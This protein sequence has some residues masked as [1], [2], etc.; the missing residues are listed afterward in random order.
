MNEL[1]ELYCDQGKYAQAEPLYTK[2]LEVQRRVLGEEHPDTLDTM[3]NLGA[4]YWNQGKY[5]QAEPLFTKVLERA[6]AR[7]GRGASRHAGHDEQPGAALPVPR[8]VCAGRATLR[9][10]PG[11]AS[12]ACWARSIP[13]R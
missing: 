9:Q 10:G 4:L 13:T 7:A 11:G 3:D 8:Q 12:G 5:A 2:V 6:A 1:A